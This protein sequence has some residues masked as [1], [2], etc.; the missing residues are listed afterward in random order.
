[1]PDKYRLNK[2]WIWGELRCQNR[3]QV[4][5]G[6]PCLHKVSLFYRGWPA[7][8]IWCT[9]PNSF[10]PNQQTLERKLKS[11]AFLEESWKDTLVYVND[12]LDIYFST[13][14]LSEYAL[15]QKLSFPTLSQAPLSPRFSESS[16][17]APHPPPSSDCLAQ[18]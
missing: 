6:V 15:Q 12:V 18:F 5:G 10:F 9:V 14:A 13:Y 16:T 17:L 11:F 4:G 7:R 1:M 2:Y 3:S 8:V